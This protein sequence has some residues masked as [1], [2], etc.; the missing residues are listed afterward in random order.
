MYRIEKRQSITSILYKFLDQK[1]YFF[2][3]KQIMKEDRGDKKLG[4]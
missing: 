4:L 2:K 3:K 1:N